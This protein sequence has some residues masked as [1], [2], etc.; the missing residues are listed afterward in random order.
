MYKQYLDTIKEWTSPPS[1]FT[2][3]HYHLLCETTTSLS[4]LQDTWLV[5]SLINVTSSVAP[6]E[7]R[8]FILFTN[9]VLFAHESGEL[10]SSDPNTKCTCLQHQIISTHSY[11]LPEY[12][13]TQV[14]VILQPVTDLP[15][16]PCSMSNSSTSQTCTLW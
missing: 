12:L 11:I 6:L 1:I 10:L 14:Q 15:C 5:S 4:P 13:V 7:N 8:S 16:P 2:S 3:F 9:T